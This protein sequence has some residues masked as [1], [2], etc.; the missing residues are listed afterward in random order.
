M[1]DSFDES[2]GQSRMPAPFHA[3]NRF[4]WRSAI[5]QVIDHKSATGARV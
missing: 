4:F 3:A 2:A 5:Q 1:I